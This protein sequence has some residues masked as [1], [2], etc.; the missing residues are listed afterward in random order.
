MEVIFRPVEVIE[1]SEDGIGMHDPEAESTMWS[2]LSPFYQ[3]VSH[4]RQSPFYRIVLY[5]KL[6]V[7]RLRPPEPLSC[8]TFDLGRFGFCFYAVFC[9]T[10]FHLMPPFPHL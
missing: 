3:E 4:L 5:S 6:V 7:H 2:L 8:R 1:K 9:N 10:A